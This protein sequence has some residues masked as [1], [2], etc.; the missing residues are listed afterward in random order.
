MDVEEG[1]RRGGGNNGTVVTRGLQDDPRLMI[2]SFGCSC[3]GWGVGAAAKF[4]MCL[5]LF[6]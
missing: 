6:A 2:G 5:H 1:R 4:N 3:P